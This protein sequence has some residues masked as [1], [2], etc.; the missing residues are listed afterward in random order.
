[1]HSCSGSHTHVPVTAT[2]C[3]PWLQ[4]LAT[5]TDE[6]EPSLLFCLRPVGVRT[7]GRAAEQLVERGDLLAGELILTTAEG[8]PRSLGELLPQANLKHAVDGETPEAATKRVHDGMY[9]RM[10]IDDTGMFTSGELSHIF[11]AAV[12][13]DDTSWSQ[14]CMAVSV[15]MVPGSAWVRVAER[16]KPQTGSEIVSEVLSAAIAAALAAHS[17]QRASKKEQ[18]S[19]VCFSRAEIAGFEVPALKFDSFI[20]VQGSYFEQRTCEWGDGEVFEQPLELTLQGMA[21]AAGERVHV[22]LDEP[23]CATITR[24]DTLGRI[25]CEADNAPT[26]SPVVLTYDAAEAF[27]HDPHHRPWDARVK[28]VSEGRLQR[29]GE[30]PVSPAIFVRPPAPHPAG[31][32]L[33][34]VR[35]GSLVQVAVTPSVP[36]PEEPTRHTYRLPTGE[37]SR[38]HLNPFNHCFPR[39]DSLE[40]YYDAIGGF[41][42]QLE[43]ETATL[44]DGITGV[45]LSTETQ[46]L[47]IEATVMHGR[48]ELSDVRT[49]KALAKRMRAPS[50]MRERGAHPSRPIL[51]RAKAGTGKTWSSWQLAHEL[52]KLCGRPTATVGRSE[53][54]GLPLVPVLV[55]VQRLV[56]VISKQPEGAPPDASILIHYFAR[57][58]GKQLSERGEWIGMLAQTLELRSLVVV[59]DGIDEAAGRRDVISR[60]IRHVL[61]PFGLRVLCTSR[62]EGVTLSDFEADFTVFDLAPL[63]DE[64]QRQALK[65]QLNGFP[66]GR[67]FSEHLTAFAAIRR[68]HNELYEERFTSTERAAIE[69]YAVPNRFFLDESCSKRNRQMRQHAADGSLIKLSH[70]PPKSLYHQSHANFFTTGLLSSLDAALATAHGSLGE[71]GVQ[72]LVQQLPH[73][74]IARLRDAHGADLFGCNA[75]D[76]ADGALRRDAAFGHMRLAVKLGLL[77]LDRRMRLQ[78]RS[79]ADEA[80]CRIAPQATARELWPVIVARTDEAYVALEELKPIFEQAFTQLAVTSGLTAEDLRFGELKDAVRI[81]EKALSDYLGD[82]DDWADDVVIAEACVLDVLRARVLCPDASSMLKLQ[83]ALQK[84]VDLPLEDGTTTVTLEAV[85]CKNKFATCDPTRF[86]NVL[87]NVRLTCKPMGGEAFVEMQVSTRRLTL[88]HSALQP[89]SRISQPKPAISHARLSLQLGLPLTSPDPLPPPLTS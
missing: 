82:F 62:P 85:R 58:Y 76:D 78:R 55:N 42:R 71:K 36:P 52:A 34:L 64:Q 13:R 33:L 23:F 14:R 60:L 59:L 44:E 67:A 41:C 54:L 8:E 24:H 17:E 20:A 69:G 10:R 66:E 53:V 57:E 84:G 89:P 40:A 4:A 70:G 73:P 47:L 43:H 39:L 81:H 2:L 86:R 68:G 7:P 88:S 72:A 45:K 25:E 46:T 26:G 31:T 65:V 15:R 29:D 9:E 21:A 27:R 1:M 48:M 18:P 61:V 80:L 87:N 49:I 3:R 32:P 28:C 19:C 63:S 35:A 30:P 56:R 83:K 77:V 16:A 37:A 22:L 12:A 75:A 79:A 74:E 50:P 38:V 5:R 51:L 6:H 11:G